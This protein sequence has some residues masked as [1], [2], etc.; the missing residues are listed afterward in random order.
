MRKLL[1][2]YGF[3][4][5]LMITDDLR[6]YGAA[7]CDL[8]I[9]RHHER[10]RW[11]NNRAENTHQPTRRRERKMQRFRA[12]AQPRNP[13]RRM[14]C[15]QHFQCPT[16]SHISRNAPK[17]SRCGDEHVACGRRSRPDTHEPQPYRALHSTM[18]RR[19]AALS[20]GQPPSSQ[21]LAAQF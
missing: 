4:P 13:F 3:V 18:T 1:K 2:K 17:L 8:G 19:L 9:E 14:R 15:L 11:K 12:S 5:D 21:W 7:A 20:D 16:P 6:S 10:G